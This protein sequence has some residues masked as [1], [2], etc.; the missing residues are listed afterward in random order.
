MKIIRILTTIEEIEEASA[1]LHLV[2]IEKMQWNFNHDNPSKLNVVIRNNRRL[3]IDKFT[4]NAVWFGVFGD[5]KLIGCCR[6]QGT[7]E[8]NLL[9]IEEYESSQVIR[10]FIPAPKNKCVELGK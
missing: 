2:Y 8:H 7:D 1:L 3:L 9:A 6:I 5:N 4:E 10:S